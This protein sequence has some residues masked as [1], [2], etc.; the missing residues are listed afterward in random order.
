MNAKALARAAIGA[1][2]LAISAIAPAQAARAPTLVA[3]GAIERGTWEL[4][5]V[6]Q[7][8]GPRL[9]LADIRDV[10]QLRHRGGAGCS[11]FV[12]AN[13]PRAATVHYTCPGRGHGRTALTVET[14][15]LIRVETQ[16]IAENQPFDLAFEARRVP[17]CRP[18]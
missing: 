18:R 17:A 15:R 11:R 3:L 16:G 12:I 10:L 14:P 8:R 6:G 9:C 7:P 2:L 13:E 4:H 5:T 1:S